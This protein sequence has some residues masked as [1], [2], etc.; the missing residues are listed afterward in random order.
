MKRIETQSIG[1][2]MRAA[3]DSLSLRE[4][5]DK[6]KAVEC[7]G[8]VVGNGIASMCAKP[9]MRNSV[10]VIPVKSAA[11]RHELN[12][13]R[14]SIVADINACVGNNVVNDLKFISL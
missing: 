2:V 14:S 7:W 9:Y 1:D 10:M 4:G 13:R 6:A 11:L 12:M 8:K 3:I 5:V